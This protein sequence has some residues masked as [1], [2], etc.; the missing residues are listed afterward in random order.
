MSAARRTACAIYGFAKARSCGA[1]GEVGGSFGAGACPGVGVGAAD[2]AE[3]DDFFSLSR[4]SAETSARSS[5]AAALA[6][7][8]FCL[9]TSVGSSRQRQKRARWIRVA[10][11]THCSAR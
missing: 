5:R 6:A 8:I 9:T 3:E 11:F 7:R 4:A 1:E 2:V 10:E